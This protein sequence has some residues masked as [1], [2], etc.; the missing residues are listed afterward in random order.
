MKCRKC[1]LKGQWRLVETY[2]LGGTHS[3]DRKSYDDVI[4]FRTFHR[5]TEKVAYESNHWIIAGKWYVNCKNS[6]LDLKQR[7]YLVGQMESNPADI[8][9][10]L[11]KLDKSSWA[12]SATTGNEDVKLYYQKESR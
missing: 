2:S 5:Y 6:F 10:K 9:F 3:V 11:F 8:H 1:V 4:R 7:K 12:A